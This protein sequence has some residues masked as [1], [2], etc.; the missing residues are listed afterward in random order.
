[1]GRR[2]LGA[3]PSLHL[4]RADGVGAA[5]G[6]IDFPDCDLFGVDGRSHLSGVVDSPDSDEVAGINLEG[7]GQPGQSHGAQRSWPHFEGALCTPRGN[8]P[9]RII[10]IQVEDDGVPLLFGREEPRGRGFLE[11]NVVNLRVEPEHSNDGVREAFP[12]TFQEFR[13]RGEDSV[14]AHAT[15]PHS[16]VRL[17]T[18]QNSKGKRIPTRPAS[19]QSLLEMRMFQIKESDKG[20]LT[21]CKQR[22]EQAV[23]AKLLFFRISPLPGGGG[24]PRSKP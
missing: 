18:R 22:R 9:Q 4:A 12:A 24:R 10:V 16:C 1:M 3:K 7:A 20:A 6:S 15:A 11:R 17:A 14:R 23:Q 8:H 19:A 2:R 5:Y 13:S 21:L